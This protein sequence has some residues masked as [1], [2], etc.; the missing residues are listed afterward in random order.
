MSTADTIRDLDDVLGSLDDA[1]AYHRAQL[2]NV[3]RDR[4]AVQRA[5]LLHLQR[6]ADAADENKVLGAHSHI[7]PGDI[8]HCATI[9]EAYTEIACRSGGLTKCAEAA[10]LIW[11]AGLSKSKSVRL[12]SDDIRRRLLADAHWEHCG[13]GIFRYLPYA[14]SGKGPGRSSTARVRPS[15][16]FGGGDG[17][18]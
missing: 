5:R 12:V 14:E 7:S 10:R 16:H 8:A 11:T 18:S 6:Q 3:K 9:R 2:E 4:E 17:P 13:P 1:E 15:R